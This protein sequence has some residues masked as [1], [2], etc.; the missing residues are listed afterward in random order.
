MATDP[1]LRAQPATRGDIAGV[2]IQ[3]AAGFAAIIVALHAIR[4]GDK[5]ALD[6]A[7][8]SVKKY[9]DRLDGLYNELVGWTPDEEEG[10]GAE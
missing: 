7:L 3:T 8:D 1:K 10:E 2:A 9:Y 6:G 5:D 4:D